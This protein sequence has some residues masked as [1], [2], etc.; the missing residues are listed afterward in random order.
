MKFWL[1][2]KPA[3]RR[4][5]NLA[6]IGKGTLTRNGVR[7]KTKKYRDQY[8]HRVLYRLKKG[9][10]PRGYDVHHRDRDNQNNGLPSLGRVKHGRHP[11][12]TFKGKSR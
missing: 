6:G 5:V 7:L 8:L 1:R 2:R 12:V 11:L 4:R 9:K 10:L 3:K